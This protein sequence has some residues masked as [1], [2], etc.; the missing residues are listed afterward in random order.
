MAPEVETKHNTQLTSAE[1]GQ[2]WTSYMSETLAVCMLTYFLEKTEDTEIKP[3]L[4]YAL[5]LSKQHVKTITSIFNHEKFPI[6]Q[7][8]TEKDVNINAPRLFSDP[9]ALYYLSFM[10]RIGGM[11]TAAALSVTARSDVFDFYRETLASS[12]ELM[13]KAR[14]VLLSKGIF[15]RA[16][17]ISTPDKVE[18]VEKQ[19][20]LAGWFGDVRTLHAVEITN[21]FISILTNAIGKA[22][23]MG[24]SQVARSKEIREYFVRGRNI[25]S[26]HTEVFSSLLRRDNVPAP[27][28]WDANVTDSQI[29]PFSDKLMMYH[30]FMLNAAGVGNYGTAI[31]SSTRR[32]LG[33]NYARLMTEV[34]LYAED[35]ANIMIENGWME[36]PPKADD[37]DKL[38]GV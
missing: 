11:S 24:F 31:A 26:K 38:A 15:I 21:L 20:F 4:D 23:C 17:H 22:L 12:G 34:G 30:I 14:K 37:R 7:G 35:G 36:Q 13:D 27:M 8:F 6:P 5:H 10:G 32:D 16:P 28:P 19:N 3:V 25:A 9:F 18:F 33:A 1:M 2:L 29:P